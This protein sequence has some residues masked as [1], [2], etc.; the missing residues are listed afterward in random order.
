MIENNT[1]ETCPKA[2]IWVHCKAFRKVWT[3]PVDRYRSN[4]MTEINKQTIQTIKGPCF[5]I[6]NFQNFASQ[7]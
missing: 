2:A 1:I 5:F 7:Q 4:S 3:Q 6:E